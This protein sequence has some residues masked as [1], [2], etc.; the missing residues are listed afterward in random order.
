M[1]V[2]QKTSNAQPERYGEDVLLE[3]ET[4]SWYSPRNFY[5]V[6]T[7]E[8][9]QSRYHVL[10]KLGYGTVSTAWLCWDLKYNQSLLLDRF[11]AAYALTTATARTNNIAI[12]VYMTGHRQALNVP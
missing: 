1:A 5:P 10:A 6:Q 8:I 2:P 12:K 3:E 7:G 9:F 4:F 11:L